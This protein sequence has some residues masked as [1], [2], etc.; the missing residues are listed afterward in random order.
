MNIIIAAVS[1]LF[2]VGCVSVGDIKEQPPVMNKVVTG[3]YAD[4]ARCVVSGMESDSRWTVNSLNYD[5]RVYADNKTSEVIASASNGYTGK[6]VA[7]RLL[8]KQI[9]KNS[10]HVDLRGMRSDTKK[11]LEYL[12]S[13]VK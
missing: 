2:M 6:I 11:A 7:F 9:D 4:I 3:N 5:V 8:S 13:C 10:A 12:K 1:L